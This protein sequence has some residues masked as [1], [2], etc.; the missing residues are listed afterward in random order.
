MVS[1][2]TTAFQL[3]LFSKFCLSWTGLTES[4]GNFS[5]TVPQDIWLGSSGSLLPACEAKLV[6]STGE[7]IT[8]YGKAGELLIRSPSICIGY[9]QNL[10]ET[11][12]L[13]DDGWMRTGDQALVRLSPKGHEH[14]FILERIKELI[15]V[16][17][18]E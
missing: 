16:K 6:S 9:Y 17:V 12:E 4:C 1:I 3:Y 7:E 5:H 8:N 14:L 13:F 18:R 11:H 10:E 2:A 15:K